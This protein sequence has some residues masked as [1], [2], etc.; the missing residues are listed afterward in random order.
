MQFP[1]EDVKVIDLS[2]ALAGPFC[3]SMLG[4]FGAHIIK[5]EVPDAGDISRAWGP[6]F[7]DSESAYFVNLHRNKKSIEVD[8]KHPQGKELFFPL[9]RAM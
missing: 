7:Y 2:H 6:P 3:S 5:L 8:L 4:D 1:L 9:D